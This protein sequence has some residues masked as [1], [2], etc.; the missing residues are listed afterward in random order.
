MENV[1]SQIKS[2]GSRVS[3]SPYFYISVLF[4]CI[5][6]TLIGVLLFFNQSKKPVS[7][8]S[9]RG[10]YGTLIVDSRVKNTQFVFNNNAYSTPVTIKNISPGSYLV[11]EYTH[12]YKNESYTIT[13]SPGKTARVD[14]KMIYLPPAIANLTPGDEFEEALSHTNEIKQEIDTRTQNNPLTQYLPEPI[15]A[16]MFDYNVN[17]DGSIQYVVYPLPGKTYDKSTYVQPVNDFIQSKGVD[18]STITIQWE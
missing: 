16:V 9:M 5:L 17:T 1:F 15:G 13:V 14:F 6:L 8:I 10:E 12:G 11:E 7:N 18:P 4:F 3:A 2:I